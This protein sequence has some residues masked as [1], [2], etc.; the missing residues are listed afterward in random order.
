MVRVRAWSGATAMAIGSA[1]ARGSEAE[2]P[3]D[4]ECAVG[5]GPFRPALFCPVFASLLLATGVLELVAAVAVPEPRLATVR[6]LLVLPPIMMQAEARP[7]GDSL[8]PL[9]LS[10]HS[11]C[12]SESE[13][14]MR[15]NEPCV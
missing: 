2:V 9:C 3:P 11:S 4:R 1:R 14:A 12:S 15:T 13:S 10:F 5:R 8:P 6:L 7:E